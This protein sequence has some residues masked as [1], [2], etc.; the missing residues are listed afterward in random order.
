MA[1]DRELAEV[2]RYVCAAPAR[3]S[4]NTSSEATDGKFQI[5]TFAAGEIVPGLQVLDAVQNGTVEMRP[6]ARNT[7]T[8]ARTRPGRCSAPCRS[9]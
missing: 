8:S 1:L 3:R 4:P 2:A 9:A 7:T 5:Q 6:H